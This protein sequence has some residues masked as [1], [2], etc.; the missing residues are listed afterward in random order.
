MDEIIT[1]LTP[2]LLSSLMLLHS[3]QDKIRMFLSLW[4]RIWPSSQVKFTLIA[5]LSSF[6]A[7][8]LKKA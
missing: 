5:S 6:K 3:L 4:A 2:Y 1:K 8:K 7:I